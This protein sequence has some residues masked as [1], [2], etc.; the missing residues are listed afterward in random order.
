MCKFYSLCFATRECCCTLPKRDITKPHVIERLQTRVNFWHVFE[1]FKCFFHLH[2]QNISYIFTLI[3]Y[4]KRFLVISF[5]ATNITF[6]I[7]IREEIHLNFNKPITRAF[8]TPSAF[9]I[10][11]KSA[12]FIAPHFSI[13]S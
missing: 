1:E 9:N 13:I 4:L 7:N 2:F 10:K 5:P 3:F 12:R 11:A 8:F 6:N